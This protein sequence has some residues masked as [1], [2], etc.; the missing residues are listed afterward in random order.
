LKKRATIKDI[1]DS[2]NLSISTV[3][4]I[5]NG[6]GEFSEATRSSVLQVAKMLDYR[7][8]SLAVSLRKNVP[9]KVVG[10]IL[11][12]VNHYFFSSILN[13]IMTSSHNQGYM[14]MIGESL[15]RS[16]LE[17]DLINNFSDHFVAGIILAPSQDKRSAENIVKMENE[18][19]PNV[20]IDRTYQRIN[21]SFVKHDDF[22]G[23][24][25]AVMHLLNQGYEKIGLIKGP[26]RCT[27]SQTRFEGYK[28]AF[29][30]KG[31][32]INSDL[33]ESANHTDKEEG[34]FL[35]KKMYEKNKP[36]AIF[37]ITDMLASGVF[38][39]AHEQNINIPKDLGVIGYSNSQLGQA[40]QPK[41]TTVNQ[42]GQEMGEVALSY[43]LEQINE[44]TLKRQLTFDSEL[45]IRESCL[46]S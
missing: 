25:N 5:L 39:Y 9:N 20:V 8:N 11:P 45:I 1:S 2:L 13:G 40:L 7:A 30:E 41:L 14:V 29:E 44:P 36:G 37:T 27:I 19:I 28:K 12:Q 6:K 24:F 31:I 38:T 18:G 4:R 16:D 21:G 26:D 32:K 33:I 43:L 34:Y 15:D 23:A 10:V 17:K 42:N 22:K 46:S 35:F 3:S